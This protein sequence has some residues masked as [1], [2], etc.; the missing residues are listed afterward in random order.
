MIESFRDE[1]ESYSPGVVWLLDQRNGNMLIGSAMGFEAQSRDIQ[2]RLNRALADG[3]H[4]DDIWRYWSTYQPGYMSVR[5]QPSTISTPTPQAALMTLLR[6][7]SDGSLPKR[8]S[9]TR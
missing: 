9:E 6:G 2:H 1:S 4:T 8:T 5:T 7:I 3:F